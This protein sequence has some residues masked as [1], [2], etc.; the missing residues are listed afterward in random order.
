MKT[1][2]LLCGLRPEFSASVVCPPVWLSCYILD[3]CSLPGSLVPTIYLNR[4]SVCSVLCFC[5]LFSQLPLQ[6][7]LL[8]PEHISWAYKA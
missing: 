1:P 5:A 6:S 7:Q 2:Q 8:E 3:V 4:D